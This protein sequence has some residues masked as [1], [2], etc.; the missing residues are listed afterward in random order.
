MEH[1]TQGHTTQAALET[2]RIEREHV[3]P[4]RQT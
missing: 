3:D 4:T 1:L 2:L